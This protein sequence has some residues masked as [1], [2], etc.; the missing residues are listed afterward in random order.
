VNLY[1]QA[2]EL[3]LLSSLLPKLEASIVIDVGAER[4][5]FTQGLL[6]AGAK[7]VYALEAHPDNAAELTRR[8]AGEPR[9][10]VRSCAVSDSD[11]EAELRLAVGR[12]GEAVV[13]GH[14]LLDRPDT[15]EI[16]WRSSIRVEKRSLESLVAAGEV[17]ARVAIL[18]VDTEGQD[19]NVV[20]G[21]GPL[22]VDV[23]MVE[24]WTDLPQGLGPC[25]WTV[26]DMREQLSPRGFLHFALIAHSDEF[27]TLQWDDGSL[28]EGGLGNLIFLHD[29]VLPLVAS[30]VLACASRLAAGAVSVGRMYM[31]AANERLE[32]LNENQRAAEE[33]VGV[34]E[35]LSQ[36]LAELSKSVQASAGAAD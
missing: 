5:A 1:G 22:D 30:E 26:D 23:V 6:D 18:K 35:R 12:D 34:I 14:T 17:P 33:R 31:D 27:I 24:H 4:G 3:E 10:G 8:F 36:E 32:A 19:L 20:R 28:Q 21:M 11:G 9:V 15:D 7:T 16:A 13:Y 29:R 25:P 2:P